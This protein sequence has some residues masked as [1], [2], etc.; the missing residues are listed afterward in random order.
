MNPK[1]RASRVPLLLGLALLGLG[2]I[3]ACGATTGSRDEGPTALATEAGRAGDPFVTVARVLRHPRC[4]NC[5]PSGEV[6]HVGDERL[7]H[8]MEVQRGPDGFGRAAMACT[9]CHQPKNQ[10]LAGIPGAPHWH[11]APRSMGWEGLDD[12]GLA[13]TLIDRTK[14]GDR[15]L[16]D[17]LLHMSEDPLVGW[18]WEPGVGRSAPTIGREE[19]VAA[20]EA[21]IRA[22]A[23]LPEPG[24]TS[25]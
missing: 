1:S 19:F 9:T 8:R 22:G 15:S 14:N 21:W 20:F 5:H 2:A 18:A 16:D 24:V 13:A 6:P 7:P 12:R 10:D 17:L 23:E 3:A 25:Y 11:L 4:L